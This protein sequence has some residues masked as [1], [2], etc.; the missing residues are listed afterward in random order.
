MSDIE[1]M[2]ILFK[3]KKNKSY[4][5][6]KRSAEGDSEDE[7][8]RKIRYTILNKNLISC[9]FKQP[10]FIS[11]KLE[12]MKD[13]QNLRKRPKGVDVIGLAIGERMN[14]NND[15]DSVS[16]RSSFKNTAF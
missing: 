5:Q 6:R 3:K 7:D 12:E 11:E 14:T 1:A 13:L 10:F 9:F 2:P 16:Y 8:T 15:V 4:R